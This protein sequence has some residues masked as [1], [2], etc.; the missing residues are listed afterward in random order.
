M[1]KP[2]A[3]IMRSLIFVH[4]WMGVALAVVFGLWFVSGIVMM[5]WTFPDVT[6]ADRLRRAPI[7]DSASV[8]LSAQEAHEKASMNGQPDQ[9]RLSNFD[10]RP[11]YRFRIGRGEAVVYADTGEQ[12][13]EVTRALSDRSALQWTG[14]PVTNASVEENTE[15]DQWTVPQ[16]YRQHRPMLKYSYADGQEVYVSGSTGEVV[17][18]TTRASRF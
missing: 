7:L 16:S 9:V 3:L 2:T 6:A 10:G 5:Y 18:Y 4:R 13:V 11:V 1:P 17:Q 14:Q 12:Q 8:R 15:E